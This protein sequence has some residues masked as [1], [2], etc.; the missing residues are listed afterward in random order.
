MSTAPGAAYAGGGPDDGA[1]SVVVMAA[2]QLIR[3]SVTAALRGLG[4]QATSRPLPR[5]ASRF[6]ETRR[7]LSQ[8]RPAVGVLVTDLEDPAQVH[9]ALAVVRHLDLPW[10]LLTSASPG[11]SWGALLEAGARDIVDAGAA[12]SHVAGVIRG[13][14]LGAEP[15]ALH[16]ATV[17][18]AW[19]RVN[20]ERRALTER[21]GRLSARELEILV[22][23]NEGLSASGI[24]ARDGVAVSTVRGQ[25]RSILRKLE[26]R[27]QLRAV[28]AYREEQQWIRNWGGR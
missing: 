11:P 28:A 13:V 2:E 25:I 3:D 27:S 21:L 7:W 24:A 23:L 16:R 18:D 5:S 12:L 15:E 10:L 14:A 9:D 4:F 17:L 8:E 19:Q 6:D 22:S 26:V 1:P 20:G